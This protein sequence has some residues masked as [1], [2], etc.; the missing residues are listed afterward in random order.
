MVMITALL[1]PFAGT[2]S[3]YGP[4]SVPMGSQSAP[5]ITAGKAGATIGELE[6]LESMPGSLGNGE[7][8]TLALPQQAVW[9]QFPATDT[10]LST[11]MGSLK[12]S[13]QIVDTGGSTMQITVGGTTAG[14][15]WPAAWFLKNL[16]V[17]TA[18]DFSG[19][20]NV[21]LG[22]SAGVVLIATLAMVNPPVATSAASV[23]AI[24][25]G[26]A[27]QAV[28]DLSII[29]TAA[30]SIAGTTTY[31]AIDTNTGEKGANGNYG[32]CL[33]QTNNSEP[34]LYV[35]APPGVTFDG[36]P[37]VTVSSGNLQLGQ[38]VTETG[39]NYL[40]VNNQGVLVI[41][42]QSGSTTASTIKIS[43][44][45]VTVDSS[46]PLGPVEFQIEG[47]AVNQ[48]T[49][50]DTNGKPIS[51]NGE[52]AANLSA[53]FPNST[54]AAE[55]AVATVATETS[56]ARFQI[57]QYSYTVNGHVYGMDVAPF[58]QNSRT[59]LPLRYVATAFGA[60]AD[61]VWDAWSQSVT[62]SK[63]SLTVQLT[64]GSTV[65][66]I[67]GAPIYMDTTPV[68]QD[69]RIFLPA[70]WVAQA[71]NDSIKWDPASRTVTLISI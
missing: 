43:G 65:M 64:N 44:I 22:D 37:D 71:L 19:L 59:Y 12:P 17:N 56:S 47:P 9:S 42:V 28:G 68:I 62:I 45:R 31:S 1:V 52:S 23:P 48:N 69:D 57:G 70:A 14:Q 4:I 13:Y 29:E 39:D 58:I 46:V 51:I 50:R 66:T 8:I 7:T 60:E 67:N 61:F 32:L 40:G 53:P 3:A 34:N 18:V 30:G 41:P 15:P 20:L 10:I 36:T 24:A 63:G 2:A 6:I 25:S 21:T 16:Q 55:T 38:P 26:Q 33:Y 54:V 49:D 35:V 5:T 27:G 11:N